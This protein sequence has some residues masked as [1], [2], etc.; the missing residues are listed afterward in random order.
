ME[1]CLGDAFAETDWGEWRKGGSRVRERAW[2]NACA[3]ERS[4][5]KYG[6]CASG[7]VR[8]AVAA[9]EGIACTRCA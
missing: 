3:K 7:R 6:T 1:E 2:A 5:S 4:V 9:E 8:A